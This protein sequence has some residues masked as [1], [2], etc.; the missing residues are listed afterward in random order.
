MFKLKV[1]LKCNYGLFS[2]ENNI[3]CQEQK[4][5]DDFSDIKILSNDAHSYNKE[6]HGIL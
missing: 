2:A 6:L 3:L 1:Q 5:Y 4:H